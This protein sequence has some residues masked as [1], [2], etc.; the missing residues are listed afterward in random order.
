MIPISLGEDA[1]LLKMDPHH[2][3]FFNIG[4]EQCPDG[5]DYTDGQNHGQG[6]Q[7][8]ETETVDDCGEFC[9]MTDKCKSFMWSPSKA[10]CK[11]YE[12]EERDA[13]Q[14]HE[15]FLLCKMKLGRPVT[16]IQMFWNTY[17]HHDFR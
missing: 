13:P 3:A 8:K 2:H 9:E 10:L 12:Q 16:Q 4:T 17:A 6:I 14:Q 7:T 15:D 5:F 1:G 11:V